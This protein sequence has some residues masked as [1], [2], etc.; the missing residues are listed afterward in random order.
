MSKLVQKGGTAK[1][2]T[3]A[4]LAVLLARRGTSTH[5]I[6]MDAQASLTRTFGLSDDADGLYHALTNR[7]GFM[8]IF[9][10]DFGYRWRFF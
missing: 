9:G 8:G 10:C 6:D 3:A 1:T 2:T 7:A 5:L 4:A